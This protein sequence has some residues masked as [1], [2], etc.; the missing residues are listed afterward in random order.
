MGFDLFAKAGIAGNMAKLDHG[1]PFKWSCQAVRTIVADDFVEGIGQK[2]FSAMRP[3]PDVEMEDPF[4]LSL[5]PLQQLLGE[6]LEVLTAFD[7]GFP[8]RT[9]GASIHKQDFYI[10]CLAQ[11]AAAEFARTHDGE[12]AW[13][14]IGQS[15]GAVELVELCLTVL[16][17]AFDDHFRQLSERLR[18][19]GKARV[20]LDDVLHVDSEQFLV[21]EAIQG[22]LPSG[23][24]FGTVHG[25]V[26][27]L[28][29]GGTRRHQ[30]RMAIIVKQRHEMV[31]LAAEKVLPEKIAGTEQLRQERKRFLVAQKR[32]S[33]FSRLAC[34]LLHRKIE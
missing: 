31:V 6:P 21:L 10:R 1:L 8:G 25:T 23:V 11:L 18:E 4:L 13:L 12:R 7:T 34:G 17:A 30:R 22:L 28:F 14:A 9:A 26:E 5:D 19:V 24:V 29:E 16:Q 20:R 2:A 3:Q 33:F 27:S 15:G 32:K